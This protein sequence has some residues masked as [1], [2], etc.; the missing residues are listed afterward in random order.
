MLY[1]S[2]LSLCIAFILKFLIP[3]FLRISRYV[4]F[5]TRL[6]I[7]KVLFSFLAL[8]SFSNLALAGSG[9]VTGTSGAIDGVII[10]VDAGKSSVELVAIGLIA[11]ASVMLGLYVITSAMSK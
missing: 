5:A 10:C 7:S 2:T 3:I 9:C 4:L 6:D 1:P 8:F 11:I